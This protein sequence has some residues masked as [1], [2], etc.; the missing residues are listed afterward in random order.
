MELDTLILDGKGRFQWVG[1]EGKSG[2]LLPGWKPTRT[3]LSLTIVLGFGVSA[4]LTVRFTFKGD[5]PATH[6][7]GDLET[8]SVIFIT[9]DLCLPKPLEVIPL[10]GS[11][12]LIVVH[13]RSYSK[14]ARDPIEF[15]QKWI[16]GYAK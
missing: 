6:V 14:D 12:N 5:E 1:F 10:A 16:H 4:R 8:S 7:L 11:P 3:L 13:V 9:C 2:C 15:D